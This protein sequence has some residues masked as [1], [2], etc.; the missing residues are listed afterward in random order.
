MPVTQTIIEIG[1]YYAVLSGVPTSFH[2]NTVGKFPSSMF[3]LD[4]SP[5]SER[6]S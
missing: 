1:K 5:P 3:P 4:H 6:E 2:N